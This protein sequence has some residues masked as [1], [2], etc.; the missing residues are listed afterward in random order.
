MP[1]TH[2][3]DIRLSVNAGMNMPLCYA[4][5][6][7]LDCDKSRLPTS[8]KIDEVTCKHCLRL[9]PKRYPWASGR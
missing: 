8:G 3:R 5:A 6:P 7:L 4:G 9:F 1:K 2:Y